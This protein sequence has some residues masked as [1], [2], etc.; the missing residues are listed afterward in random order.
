MRRG[1]HTGTQPQACARTAA[2]HGRR[3]GG[4]AKGARTLA[5]EPPE[6]PYAFPTLTLAPTLT[7]TRTRTRTPTRTLDL[8]FTPKVRIL[9]EEP[10]ERVKEARR[11]EKRQHAAKKRARR[12]Q[13]D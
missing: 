3:G 13:D 11:R 8:T 5:D 9:S 6:C 1:A 4:R 12:G 10:P 7:R 2:G